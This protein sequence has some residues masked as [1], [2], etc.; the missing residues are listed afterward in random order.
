MH[1]LM[2]YT[3]NKTLSYDFLSAV[4]L[5]VASSESVK[6]CKSR[7]YSTLMRNS[8]YSTWNKHVWELQGLENKLHKLSYYHLFLFI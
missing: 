1:S 3:L 8:G 6:S 7:V 4:F 5:K 2:D